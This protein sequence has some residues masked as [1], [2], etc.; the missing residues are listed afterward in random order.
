MSKRSEISPK[1]AF[2]SPLTKVSSQESN[3]STAS[4]Q[5][6]IGKQKKHK[7][8]KSSEK[9]EKTSLKS[10]SSGIQPITSS[11]DSDEVL[12]NP[13]VQVPVKKVP[14]KPLVEEQTKENLHIISSSSSSES[15]EGD[16]TQ[17][18]SGKSETS[19]RK[20]QMPSA[21]L[22]SGKSASQPMASTSESDTE[23]PNSK[24][25]TPKTKKIKTESQAKITAY[26][27]PK[28]ALREKASPKK[29]K[30][31]N[32]AENVLK[33]NNEPQSDVDQDLSDLAK[34][35][36][37]DSQFSDAASEVSFSLHG[38]PRKA[39][40]PKK[41]F[42]ENIVTSPAKFKKVMPTSDSLN[43]VE[44]AK[45]NI[46]DS[47]SKAKKK[48]KEKGD[49][50]KNKLDD[51]LS[52]VFKSPSKTKKG[53][54]EGRNTEN[55]ETNGVRKAQKS[56]ISSEFSANQHELDISVS[57]NNE[58]PDISQTNDHEMSSD[59]EEWPR[60]NETDSAVLDKSRK[61]RLPVSGSK[62]HKGSSD[63][64][65]EEV[66][67]S[68]K[69][70][71]AG[72]AGSG[73]GSP[74]KSAS[75]VQDM[76][77]SSDSEVEVPD[78]QGTPAP[79][80]GK[81]RQ[82]RFAVPEDMTEF[83][84]TPSKHRIYLEDVM[85]E[86]KELWLIQ[87]PVDFDVS[88]MDGQGVILN[89]S[90]PLKNGDK[91]RTYEVLSCRDDSLST[92]NLNLLLPRKADQKLKTGL[93]FSGRMTIVETVQVPS[94]QIP[95]PVVRNY[96]LPPGLRQRFQPFGS[97][98]PVEMVCSVHSELKKTE[99]KKKKKKKAKEREVAEDANKT[100]ALTNSVDAGTEYNQGDAK[101][102]KHSKKKKKKEKK[103]HKKNKD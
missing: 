14:T 39:H 44:T 101:P 29:K 65:E 99:K 75:K 72:K 2:F 92:S 45:K 60:L 84:F 69:C 22:H 87:T 36:A 24:F 12:R 6:G 58:N 91:E 20:R 25:A 90:Q 18:L 77:E 97:D 50:N 34:K 85:K 46:S 21:P 81:K 35:I 61:R 28:S 64:S 40:L 80:G 86:G 3:I 23:L 8:K 88:Q 43:D 49:K 32:K 55:H 7:K 67:P 62:D 30:E 1:F 4:D 100:G 27:S 15:E 82:L 37:D 93:P 79:S 56:V 74:S 10:G 103:K 26:L 48:K 78:V 33:P 13:K 11:E 16:Q 54:I 9:S 89:G 83:D 59:A 95:E 73:M 42:M 66:Q 102:H 47:P 52:A 41:R 68:Q 5:E 76:S 63:D 19:K 71:P 70:S 57:L 98:S 31:N 53:A 38:S 94:V 96:D 17:M 51:T